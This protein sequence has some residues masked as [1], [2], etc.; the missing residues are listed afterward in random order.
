MKKTPAQKFF[1]FLEFLPESDRGTLSRSEG[2]C[3]WEINSK[4]SEIIKNAFYA[5]KK[6]GL[7]SNNLYEN[8]KLIKNNILNLRYEFSVNDFI[9]V[10]IDDFKKSLLSS[11]QNIPSELFIFNGYIYQND[12][13]SPHKSLERFYVRYENL[14]KILA[15]FAN[16]A[17]HHEDK[18][19][20]M[21]YINPAT[22]SDASNVKLTTKLSSLKQYTDLLDIDIDFKSLK[23]FSTEKI[24]HDNYCA[25]EKAIL[26][27]TVVNFISTL[28]EDD[29]TFNEENATQATYE[30][31]NK[32]AEFDAKFDANL[33]VYLK[34][35]SI[36]KLKSD[37][38]QE[39]I[40]LFESVNKSLQE[41]TNRVMLI[42]GLGA[43]T[44]LLRYKNPESNDS[45]SFMLLFCVALVVTALVVFVSIKNQYKII[46][47]LESTS[48]ISH[49]KV[50][51]LSDNV[52]L[53]IDEIIKNTSDL[54]KS[55]KNTLNYCEWATWGVPPIFLWGIGNIFYS[56][57]F[58]IIYWIVKACI[59]EGP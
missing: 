16:N 48:K 1:E 25:R 19:G 45:S 12:K 27:N 53:D 3:V 6:D 38:T 17:H 31:L 23:S 9:Y 2:F 15:V 14:K 20:Y 57:L 32:H 28:S 37:L 52:R 59:D 33:Q 55:T 49:E 26:R 4:I 29:N 21:I 10:D 42:P 24:E 22:D 50:S 43:M 46:D 51:R 18:Q 40:K 56:F 54:I 58:V 34:D 11:N 41:V 39:Q 5:L 13:K 35:I 44:A 47:I 30:L 7:S 8:Q 36:D